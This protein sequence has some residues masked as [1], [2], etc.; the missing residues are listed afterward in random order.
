MCSECNQPHR[1]KTPPWSFRPIQ[2]ADET[3]ILTST[4]HEASASR[5]VPSTFK[6]RS[7]LT[8]G[9]AI[10]CSVLACTFGAKNM[11][12][13]YQKLRK[14]G[15]HFE[16][17]SFAQH[18]RSSSHLSD[19]F[20]VSS[21]PGAFSCEHDPSNDPKQT[22]NRKQQTL[23]KR[24]RLGSAG[25]KTQQNALRPRAW[26]PMRRRPGRV[27]PSALMAKGILEL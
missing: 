25:L 7:T 13:Y 10:N 24:L 2:A 5:H 14:T 27:S 8:L 16:S 17:Q 21:V 20:A 15:Q 11:A 12:Q 23:T 4:K 22:K 6:Q 18:S 26:S 1:T 19:L 9:P 3:S